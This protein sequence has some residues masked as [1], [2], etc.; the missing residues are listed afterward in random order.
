MARYRNPEFEGIIEERDP[1]FMRGELE[2]YVRERAGPREEL[3]RE[4]ARLAERARLERRRLEER[5]VQ[6]RAPQA[7]YEDTGWRTYDEDREDFEGF[8]PY[9][10][11]QRWRYQ[12]DAPEP[13]RTRESYA[14]DFA[15]EEIAG[16][17]LGRER[18]FAE[19]LGG[20][21]GEWS[22]FQSRVPSEDWLALSERERRRASFAGRGPKN[23]RRADSRILE[24]VCD[25][26]TEHPGLDP[27]DV[28]VS[29]EQGEVILDGLVDS[30]RCKRLAE[31]VAASVR[32]VHDVHNRLRV[33]AASDTRS[34]G[35]NGHSREQRQ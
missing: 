33:R 14:G 16:G 34:A 4:R 9:D 3:R 32:G 30:R 27:S 21:G 15:G 24:D 11:G 26:L 19:D 25:A 20:F 23:Y 2:G 22:R 29:V 5:P 17:A 12:G 18:F 10:Y 6:P 13:R 31:D 1:R 28:E 8:G 35:G 7:G